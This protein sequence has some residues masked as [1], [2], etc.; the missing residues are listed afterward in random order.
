MGLPNASCNA[1]DLDVQAIIA[2]VDGLD[3]N[4]FLYSCLAGIAKRDDLLLG[5]NWNFRRQ[6]I[7]H[8]SN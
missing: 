7:D 3:I 6:L 8:T 2:S 4:L 5:F 1:V